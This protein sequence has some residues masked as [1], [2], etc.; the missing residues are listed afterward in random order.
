MFYVFP[1]IVEGNYPLVIGPLILWDSDHLSP[2]K[3]PLGI[4]KFG[5]VVQ[6]CKV[7]R[8]GGVSFT[9]DVH[10]LGRG[11]GEIGMKGDNWKSKKKRRGQMKGKK[12]GEKMVG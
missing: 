8:S 9:L 2:G 6:P 4:G 12:R 3:H 1:K 5:D 7:V 10:L 11:R